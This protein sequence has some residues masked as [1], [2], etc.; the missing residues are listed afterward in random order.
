MGFVPV[1][2][3]ALLNTPIVNQ[4]AEVF[5]KPGVLSCKLIELGH[6]YALTVRFRPDN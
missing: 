3:A 6:S 5:K 1:F 2:Y 4:V